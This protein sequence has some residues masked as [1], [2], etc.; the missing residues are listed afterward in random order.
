MAILDTKETDFWSHAQTYLVHQKFV[1]IGSS[2]VSDNSS[3]GPK[4][5]FE[6][7]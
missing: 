2:S 5:G 4:G 6:W 3:L 7:L 1:S